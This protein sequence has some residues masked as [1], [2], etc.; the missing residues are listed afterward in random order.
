MAA[1]FFL[2]TYSVHFCYLRLVTCMLPVRCLCRKSHDI[3]WRFHDRFILKFQKGKVPQ[4]LEFTALSELLLFK[5]KNCN[6]SEQQTACD[7]G[8]MPLT[9]HILRFAPVGAKRAPL[10]LSTCLFI[11]M[12]F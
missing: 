10:A 5:K 7:A 6:Y 12:L 8:Y 3:P 1:V 2:L 11:S 4:T 9:R